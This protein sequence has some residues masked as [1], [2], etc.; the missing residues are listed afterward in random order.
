[1]ISHQSTASA[2]TKKIL[3]SVFA[4]NDLPEILV[5][6][7]GPQFT[8]KEFDQFTKTNGIK[9]LKYA[10]YHPATNGL[11]ERFLQTF[12]HSLCAMKWEANSV[13]RK[14]ANFLM[15]Y[16]NAPHATTNETAAKLFYGRNFPTRLDTLKPHLRWDMAAK[17]MSQTI[18]PTGQHRELTVGQSVAV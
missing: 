16:I 12:K 5:R 1:M 7:N 2:K 11:A 17:Q 10:P 14:L 6:D 18:R 3:R 13:E 15:A 4:R 9:H 8:S